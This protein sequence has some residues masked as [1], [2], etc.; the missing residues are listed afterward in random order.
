MKQQALAGTALCCE[1]AQHDECLVSSLA[2]HVVRCGP[3]R[4]YSRTVVDAR[5]ERHRHLV[6]HRCPCRRLHHVWGIQ[7]VTWTDEEISTLIVFGLF[8]VRR[9]GAAYISIGFLWHNVIWRRRG[10]D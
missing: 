3:R 1:D 8:A 7:A 2:R 4:A 10:C 9:A 6:D 5:S